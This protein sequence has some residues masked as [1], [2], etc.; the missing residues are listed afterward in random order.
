MVSDVEALQNLNLRGLGP[1][2]VALCA[3]VV[4]VGAAAAVLPAAALVL[5]LGLAIAGLLAPIVATTLARRSGRSEARLRGELAAELVETVSGAPELVVYGRED[6]RLRSFRALDD[7]LARIARRAAFADGV[8]DALRLV[9][10][11]ATV[12]TVLAVAVLAHAAGQLDRVLIALLALLALASFEAVQPLGQAARELVETLAAGRRVLHLIEREPAVVDPPHPRPA[13]AFPFSVAFQG[14]RVRYANTGPPALD[15]FDLRLEPGRRL[16]LVGPSGAGKTTVANLLLR[17]LDPDEGRVVLADADLRD[18]RMED[19][20]SVV[21]V[22][23]QDSH[24]FS[25]SIRDNILL[26]REATDA[27]LERAL[28]QARLEDWVSSLPKGLDTLVGEAGAQVSGGQRQ[29]IVLARALLGR[30]P[31][32][33]LDEPTAH[34]DV[35]TAQQLMDDVFAAAGARSVLLITH[36]SEGLDLVDEVI[37]IPG[38]AAA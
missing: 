19:V 3:S 12:A 25:A 18:Y 23:G 36:R 29:R 20:R 13:P 6:D 22:A 2:L 26:G 11:G 31:L 34:L 1:P 9:V 7:R 32:L 35:P 10:A 24:L 17:F 21:A 16:A 27:D 15:G 4:S 8:A 30:E 14:V 33:V 38:S 37:R 5:A 28:R